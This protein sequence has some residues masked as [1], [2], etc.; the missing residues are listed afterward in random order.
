MIC[1]FGK[2]EY[3][4]G[5]DWT[6]RN[7]LDPVQEIRFYAQ[8][9]WMHAGGPQPRVK[10]TGRRERSDMRMRRA[11]QFWT[12]EIDPRPSTTHQRRITWSNPQGPAAG[13]T[14]AIT[15]RADDRER[16]TGVAIR[17]MCAI[18]SF[19]RGQSFSLDEAE[20][21]RRG[22]GGAAIEFGSLRR[23]RRPW[24]A[25]RNGGP[26]RNPVHAYAATTSDANS[27]SMLIPRAEV[28]ASAKGSCG[29]WPCTPV[30]PDMSASAGSC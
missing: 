6:G 24:F 21:R 30:R 27:G 11:P 20:L 4:F 7:R 3:F 13:T 10:L 9:G 2:P 12:S 18:V 8:S 28:G 23:R 17:L 16:H 1:G 22:F 26:L 19:E 25:R 14:T 15:I 29:K 5:G